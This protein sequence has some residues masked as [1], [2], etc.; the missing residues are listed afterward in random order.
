[1]EQ[2]RY[3]SIRQRLL[4]EKAD[5]E[6]RLNETDA[7]QLERSARDSEGELSY[8]DNHPADTATTLYEREKD[9]SLYE[10][11][12][13]QLEEIDVAL[14][15]MNEGVYGRCDVCHEEISLERL[16]AIPTTKYCI[17]HA[18]RAVFTNERPVEEQVLTGF[19]QFNFDGRED[20]TQ[21]DAEDAWQAVERYNQLPNS[22]HDEEVALTEARHGMNLDR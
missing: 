1:M 16:E 2:Q 20:E 4:A 9:L 18:E 3:A 12:Q 10:H 5:I 14:Q 8:Y 17:R 7:Y 15:R 6:R 22:N 13:K 11:A 21:F 19:D